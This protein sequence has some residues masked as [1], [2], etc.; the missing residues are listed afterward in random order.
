VRPFRRRLEKLMHLCGAGCPIETAARA[1]EYDP[2][3]GSHEGLRKAAAVD[4]YE[5]F[6]KGAA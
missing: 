2:R 6:L 5:G 3:S 1:M 4:L